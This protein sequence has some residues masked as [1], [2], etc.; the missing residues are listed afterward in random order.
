[1]ESSKFFQNS[2]KFIGITIIG[3]I[4][5]YFSGC[6]DNTSPTTSPVTT[7]DQFLQSVVESGYSSNANDP[8]NIM[9]ETIS[10]YDDGGAVYDNDGGPIVNPLDS[11]QR[12][13]RKVLNA[14]VNFSITSQGDTMKTVNITRTINGI[15]IIIGWQNGQLDSVTKP[16]TEV[17]HRNVMFKRIGR[18]PN[19]RFNWR[20]YSISLVSGGTTQPQNASITQLMQIQF[21]IDGS[22]NPAY[23]FNGP[24]FTQNTFVV[25]MFHGG[26][27]PIIDRNSQV[28]VVVTVN[29]TEQ[30]NYV[31]W[32]WPRNTFG[33]HRVPFTLVSSVS[34]GQGGY[35]N[36]FQKTF[37]IFSNHRL[38]MCNGFINASTH[39]S[40][41]DDD[42]GMFASSEAGIM[43]WVER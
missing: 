28:R 12:W 38:G 21:Y 3:L 39:E 36:T 32:H 43:Y 29:S 37:T 34:N 40:L 27:I 17:L 31:A 15:F 24:D 2:L 11:L 13:G 9:S 16:Y 20:L 5:I 23:T 6:S 30:N 14:N 19:P 25:R 7:D 10:D 8:D 22:P 4:F 18:N 33:F 26:G 35:T 42:P 1:M 41:Y